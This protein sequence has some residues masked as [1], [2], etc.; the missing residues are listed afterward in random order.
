MR[1]NEQF[2]HS[3]HLFSFS[4]SS[5]FFTL[6]EK[7]ADLCFLAGAKGGWAAA[8]VIGAECGGGVKK[9]EK[10]MKAEKKSRY[11]I[12]PRIGSVAKSRK[13]EFTGWYMGEGGRGVWNIRNEIE[14]KRKR[15]VAPRPEFRIIYQSKKT[16][17]CIYR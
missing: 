5:F 11:G 17:I 15:R 13:Q 4:H 8:E 9:R 7:P 10:L 14:F 1:N 3:S 2:V 12:Y 6:Y 16:S